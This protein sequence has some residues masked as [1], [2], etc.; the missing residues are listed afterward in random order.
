MN[1]DKIFIGR[2][3]KEYR[4][5]LKLT[6]EEVSYRIDIDEKHYGKLERGLYMP[7]LESFFKLINVLNI[8]L[9][10]FGV[11]KH[12]DS[13]IKNELMPTGKINSMS[14]VFLRY[15]LGTCVFVPSIFYFFN[16]KIKKFDQ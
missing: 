11:L 16:L 14:L 13:K 15:N 4:K 1:L 9:D 6:Q 10:E 5:K 3:L 7:S 2:K 12:S 8:P